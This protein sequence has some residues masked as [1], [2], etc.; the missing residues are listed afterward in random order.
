MWRALKKGS[1]R[2]LSPAPA[3]P[4][5]TRAQAGREGRAMAALV[6]IQIGGAEH[7]APRT[8]TL[9][10]TDQPGVKVLM[11]NGPSCLRGR[12]AVLLACLVR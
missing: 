12:L 8:P 6:M 9:Y 7:W 11:C 10:L 3:G 1:T 5:S 4:T 2:K